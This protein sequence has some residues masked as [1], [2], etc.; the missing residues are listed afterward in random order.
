M[1]VSVARTYRR[2]T[3]GK[4]LFLHL[5]PIRLYQHGHS[6]LSLLTH[7][8]SSGQPRWLWET[9]NPMNWVHRDRRLRKQEQE[10][11]SEVCDS[12]GHEE[13]RSVISGPF[14]VRLPSLPTASLGVGVSL[15]DYFPSM[16]N[17]NR[18]A[19]SAMPGT[20]VSL[21]SLMGCSQSS[22]KV[23]LQQPSTAVIS[24]R[25]PPPPWGSLSI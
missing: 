6:Q 5:A 19:V 23:R 20:T 14:S 4:F 11:G 17:G 13:R 25:S 24:G 7:A 15:G 16:G 10:V 3:Y 2:R 9:R 18:G 8:W 1:P 12:A 21:L 22:E